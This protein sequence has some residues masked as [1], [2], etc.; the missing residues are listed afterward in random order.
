MNEWRKIAR[1]G[2]GGL[3]LSFF[4]VCETMTKWVRRSKKEKSFTFHNN[5]SSTFLFF[6]LFFDLL[7]LV[8]V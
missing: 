1:V 5:I 6:V 3:L 8:L 4:A 2:V 7:L